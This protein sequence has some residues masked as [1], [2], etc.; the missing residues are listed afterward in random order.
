MAN[1]AFSKSFRKKIALGKYTSWAVDLTEDSLETL[2]WMAGEFG[3][4]SL[5]LVVDDKGDRWKK[6]LK[7]LEL[8]LPAVA[9]IRVGLE[10]MAQIVNGDQL[11]LEDALPRIGSA[12]IQAK[13]A[14]DE[15]PSNNKIQ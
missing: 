10:V 1:L 14:R 13:K 2:L 8:N 4:R 5:G 9:R 15:S 12:V 11:A 7:H 6:Y 3:Y